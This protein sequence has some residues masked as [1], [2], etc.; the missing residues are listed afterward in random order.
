M[1]AASLSHWTCFAMFILFLFFFRRARHV[2]GEIER[3]TAAV[4]ALK[5]ADYSTFGQLMVRP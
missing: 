2:I 4:E 3:T 5:N 1:D